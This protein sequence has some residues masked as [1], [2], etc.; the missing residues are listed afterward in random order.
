MPAPKLLNSSSKGLYN[1][2]IFRR[3]ETVDLAVCFVDIAI[4]NELQK[5]N[6]RVKFISVGEKKHTG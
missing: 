5:W 4:G 2:A 1:I 3:R 6:L